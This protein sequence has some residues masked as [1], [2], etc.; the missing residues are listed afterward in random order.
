MTM[1]GK[2]IILAL[3]SILTALPLSAMA[4]EGF[5]F[6]ILGDSHS[7]VR[8]ESSQKYVLLPVEDAAPESHVRIIANNQLATS[9]NVRLAQNHVDYYVPLE[10][11]SYRGK[12]VL[13]DVRSEAGRDGMLT[14]SE[15]IWH[16]HLTLSETFDKRNTEIKWRPVYH[17]TPEYAWMND[18]NGMFYKDGVW[19][20]FYQY[21]P[22]G[23]TWNNM[24]WGHSVSNDLM[25]W[26]QVTDALKPDGLGMIFSGSCAVDSLNSAG[27]GKDAIIAMYTQ[28][29][30]SQFQSIAYSTDGGVTFTP[31]EQNPVLTQPYEF[32]DPHVF[33]HDA[34]GKWIAV[35]AS[36]LNHEMDIY[37]S[38]DLKTWKKESSF[39]K[40]YGSQDG[41]W[42]C[43]DLMELPIRGTNYKKWVFICN[44]NPGGPF[45]GSATQYFVGDFDGKTFVCDNGP[46]VQKWMDWGKDHY[47]SVS[48]NSAPNGRHTMIAW[49]SNWQYANGVPTKQFRSANSLPRDVE[50]Y[51]GED[52]ELYLASY[53]SPEV[54]AARGKVQNIGSLKSGAIKALPSDCVGSCEVEV[55]LSAGKARTATLIL[56]NK[57]GEEVEMTFNMD[58]HKLRFCR[59]NSG[60]VSFSDDFKTCCE[61]PLPSGTRHNVRIFIDRSSI[62]IFEAEGRYTMT[63]IVFPNEPYTHLKLKANGAGAKASVKCYPIK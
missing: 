24:T 39:G 51:R 18:P 62:E 60:E 28:A 45:G 38:S 16:K 53:P 10:L 26:K 21:G 15:A 55:S 32:R 6:S 43:P 59:E 54:D 8:I 31:Y 47:A 11:T 61:A 44:I 17:H 9:I 50:L 33:R 37:S 14:V 4:D 52:G 5:T 25:N 2:Q 19:H 12:H 58:E 1:K 63:N 29:D 13:L 36:A 48:W 34:S 7:L 42:E 41:V 46:E 20:L 27:Y 23:S 35:L 49:M 57:N 40:G 3:F 30:R 56:F 22:Y